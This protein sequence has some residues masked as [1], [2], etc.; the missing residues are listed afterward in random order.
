MSTTDEFVALPP[1]DTSNKS[2][3]SYAVVNR[4]SEPV[5]A[6]VEVGPNGRDYAT[7]AEEIV[8]DGGTAIVVPIKFQRYTRLL[9]KSL[10]EG[11]PTGVT[12][13]FQSQRVR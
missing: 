12:V 1:Q 11:K 5:I 4:G 3:Y 6:Q 9:V 2:V 8:P 7:D 10:N 13:Y